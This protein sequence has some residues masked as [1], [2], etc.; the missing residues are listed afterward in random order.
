MSDDSL[1]AS[2]L[3]KKYA[4]GGTATDSELSAAQVRARYGIASNSKGMFEHC[5]HAVVQTFSS[6]TGTSSRV[7]LVQNSCLHDSCLQ[8]SGPD[9]MVRQTV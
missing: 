4:A 7:E 2:E 6:P 9:Q 8:I 1:T 5:I 3:R